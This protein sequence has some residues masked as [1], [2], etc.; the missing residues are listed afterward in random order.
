MA[1]GVDKQDDEYEPVAETRVTGSEIVESLQR[2]GFLRPDDWDN[3]KEGRPSLD[4]R[5]HRRFFAFRV[6]PFTVQIHFDSSDPITV[7]AKAKNISEGGILLLVEE[8]VSV[9][10]LIRL[11][12]AFPDQPTHY[13]IANVRHCSEGESGERLVGAAFVE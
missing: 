1:F 11:D 3:S 10:D 9:G 5:A 7:T 8:S 2:L 4:T 13:L 6:D 12:F